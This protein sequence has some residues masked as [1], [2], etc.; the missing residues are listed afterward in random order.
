LKKAE[1]LGIPKLDA[2]SFQALLD[3]GDLPA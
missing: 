3:T 1:D 2:T